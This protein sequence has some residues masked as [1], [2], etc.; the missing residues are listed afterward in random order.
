MELDRIE[1]S[2]NDFYERV[3]KGYFYLAEKEPRFKV[4]NG[5]Q[6]INTIHN[7]IIT[8]VEKFEKI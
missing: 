2:K 6:D 7:E 4:L 3:R 5:L 1:L 8:E